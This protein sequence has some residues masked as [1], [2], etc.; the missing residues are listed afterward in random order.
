MRAQSSSMTDVNNPDPLGCPGQKKSN[1][2]W[3]GQRFLVNSL[4]MPALPPLRQDI[5]R[6]IKELHEVYV[7]NPDITGCWA[8]Q[9]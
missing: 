8:H 9:N 4:Y 2:P 6:C 7:I 3:H 5:D 1:F